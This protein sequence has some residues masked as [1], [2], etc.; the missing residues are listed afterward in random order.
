MGSIYSLCVCVCVCVCVC[1]HVADTK[2]ELINKL[3][4]LNCP[5]TS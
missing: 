4:V 1:R 3:V 2:P 5:H